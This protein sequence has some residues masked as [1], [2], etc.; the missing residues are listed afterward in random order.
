MQHYLGSYPAMF[1]LPQL[2]DQAELRAGKHSDNLSVPGITWLEEDT[3]CRRPTTIQ[4]KTMPLDSFTTVEGNWTPKILKA[5]R[6]LA[7]WT[8]RRRLPEI[9][10]TIEKYPEVAIAG[11]IMSRSASRMLALLFCQPEQGTAMRPE[12]NAARI[13][14]ARSISPAITQTRRRLGIG[15]ILAIPR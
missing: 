1:A 2:M 15:R 12:A 5:T 10:S 9:K 11:R 6:T 14:S 3:D 8:S 13:S 4:T 7:R